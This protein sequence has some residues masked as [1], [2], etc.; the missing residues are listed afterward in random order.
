MHGIDPIKDAASAG[1]FI[2]VMRRF[3]IAPHEVR[4]NHQQANHNHA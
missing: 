1:V 2:M 4:Q 3:V